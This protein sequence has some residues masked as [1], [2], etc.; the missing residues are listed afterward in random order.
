MIFQDNIIKEYL[1][2]VYFI[3]GTPCGGKTTVSRALSKRFGIPVYDID[4]HFPVHQALSDKEHQPNMN[5]RF[6]SAD[7]FFGRKPEEY[8]QWL[9]DNT[10][11]QLDFVLLDIMRLSQNGPVICDCH[12]TLDQ[13]KT[14]TDPSRIAFMLRK[15]VDIVDEYCNRLDHQGFKQFIESTTD[16]EAAKANCNETLCSLNANPYNSIKNSDYF[17][18]ERDENRTVEETAN[19]VAKHFGWCLFEAFE[20]QKVD[21]GTPLA[22]DLLKFI[23]GCSWI[24][25][26]EHIAN[27]VRNWEFSD[28]ETMFVAKVN[29]NIIGMASVMKEDYY[30]LPELYPWVS[31]VFVSEEYRGYRISGKLIDYANEYL[32]EQGFTRSYIPTP[33]ENA[34]LYEHF[35]YSF[36]KGITNY[37]GDDDFLYSKEIK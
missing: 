7:E 2:N 31:C 35:G 26:K 37:G 8:K 29:G 10:R 21:K 18:L 28:W 23:E 33:W 9:L 11:E 1:R 30:P 34:G 24:E 17:W 16:P 12:L 19:L 13:A 6:E 20:I 27:L 14:L 22:D 5:K 15:P 3:T 25:V 36:V 32:K 4:E